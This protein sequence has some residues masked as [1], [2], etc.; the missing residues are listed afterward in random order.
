MRSVAACALAAAALAFAATGCARSSAPSTTPSPPPPTP[1]TPAPTAQESPFGAPVDPDAL[2]GREE[3]AREV[4]PDLDT[5]RLRPTRS[6]L[7]RVSLRSA[8]PEP[9]INRMHN[10]FVRVLD[11]GGG[12]ST[13]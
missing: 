2:R 8:V 10:W 9:G 7:Y 13:G 3:R 6:G 12:R 4:P 11:A 1:P 5:R